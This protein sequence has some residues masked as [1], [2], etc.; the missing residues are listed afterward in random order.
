MSMAFLS[1]SSFSTTSSINSSPKLSI[2]ASGNLEPLPHSGVCKSPGNVFLFEQCPDPAV[3]L[4][5][6]EFTS[7]KEGVRVM[8]VLF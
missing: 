1:P 8:I 3:S 7:E 6:P 5:T 2:L 4:Y